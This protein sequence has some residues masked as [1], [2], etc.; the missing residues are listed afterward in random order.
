MRVLWFASAVVLCLLPIMVSAEEPVLS[1]T[2]VPAT[3]EILPPGFDLSKPVYRFEVAALGEGKTVMVATHVLVQAGSVE[4]LR[5]AR[6]DGP[7][8]VGGTIAVN[9]DGVATYQAELSRPGKPDQITR[10]TVAL[11]WPKALAA[12]SLRPEPGDGASPAP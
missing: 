5:A 9:P 1:V 10:G 3:A 2:L 8:V 12:A 7:L 4:K 6:P 11:A